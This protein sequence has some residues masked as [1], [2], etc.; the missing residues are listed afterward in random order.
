MTLQVKNEFEQ[1]FRA[2]KGLDLRTDRS[3]IPYTHF[4]YN[5]NQILERGV[6]KL[7]LG[8]TEWG[9]LGF[10]TLPGTFRSGSIV[11]TGVD[12][13]GVFHKGTKLYYGLKE[14][15]APTAM[16]D[17][18]GGAVTVVDAESEITPFGY[19]V[20]SGGERVIKLLF[21]Q[22]AGCK[23][24][25]FDGT[26][27]KCRNAGIANDTFSF[28]ISETGGGINQ[29]IGAY[30]VRVVARRMVSDVCT[31][32]SAPSGK[33]TG[34]GVDDKGYQE[35]TLSA[36]TNRI[37]VNLV[38]SGLDS[39]VTHWQVQVT[40]ALNFPSGSV[41]SDNGNDP[42]IYFET[43][44]VPVTASPQ[45]IQI[46][47]SALELICPDLIGYE[48]VPGH[49][50]S[51]YSGGIL[52]F[53]GVN[54][55]PSRIYK[56]GISG[57]YYH[58]ELYNP[59]EFY[60]ADEGDG[61]QLIG[62]SEVSDH[63]F[64]IKETKTGIVPNKALDGLIIWRDFRLGC[65]H[66]KAF[67]QLTKDTMVIL[68][69]DGVLRR[70]DGV[71]YVDRVDPLSSQQSAFSDNVRAESEE[72]D[73]STVSFV[74]H[75]DRLHL[76]YGEEGERKALVLHPQEDFAWTS[77]DGLAHDFSFLA[78]NGRTWV[79]FHE[80]L[81]W[82]QNF[83][84]TFTD[85]GEDIPWEITFAV[86]RPELSPRNIIKMYRCSV[87]GY[88]T[89]AVAGTLNCNAGYL[90]TPSVNIVP[91]PALVEN[92]FIQW[93]NVCPSTAA[94]GNFLE[95]TLSGIGNHFIRGINW[96]VVERV[97]RKPIS[98]GGYDPSGLVPDWAQSY[99]DGG[100]GARVDADYDEL[101]GQ[102]GDRDTSEADWEDV[103]AEG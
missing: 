20:G 49:L 64:V 15:S 48:P 97:G 85:R 51:T 69:N 79:Y 70:F 80:D 94:F 54:P 63:L 55:F 12:D 31:S 92:Q 10:S 24:M 5:Q 100:F 50:I 30:R 102:Y 26:V 36:S 76:I 73:S 18:S 89:S 1:E 46:D 87:E 40:K 59:F 32:E 33:S 56:S 86:L 58:N 23:I 68:C 19:S 7:R 88:F 52:F 13:Y 103:D 101:D 75:A 95:L 16:L 93:F 4:T 99:Y 37:Q 6:L 39:Q 83:P 82:E 34:T 84:G 96:D 91:D 11:D 53:G 47:V 72:I 71:S 35:V 65:L 22:T 43:L 74:Y 8:S 60:S 57:F 81:L 27:W 98:Q 77:W 29:P 78:D 2:W 44:S 9:A 62:L 42:T 3:L 14:A 61:T 25:E 17:V 41:Y 21:K 90:V 67:H 38:H 66:R 45:A 28:T